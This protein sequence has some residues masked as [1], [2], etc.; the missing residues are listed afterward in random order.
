M[1]GLFGLI[2]GGDILL[3]LL[4]F[5]ILFYLAYD[6]LR[7]KVLSFLSP[8]STS[9]AV[10]MPRSTA[11]N[12]GFFLLLIGIAVAAIIGAFGAFLLLLVAGGIGCY[13]ERERRKAFKVPLPD[14]SQERVRLLK[15]LQEGKISTEEC[16]DLLGALERG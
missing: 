13:R 3:L 5:G 8:G 11:L 1:I 2:S 4:V 14:H 12:G 9:D 10:Q 7:E 15:M 6:K 16:N